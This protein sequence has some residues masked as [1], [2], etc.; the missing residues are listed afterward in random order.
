M[1]IFSNNEILL[2]FILILLPQLGFSQQPNGKYTIVIHGGAGSMDPNIEESSKQ[3]YLNSLTNALKIGK[4]ILE[5]DGASL[6]AVEQVVKFLE[7]DSLFNA[8]RGAVFTAE[9]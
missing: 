3:A 7:D 6:D 4:E 5:N 2:L 8:G 9:G 1:K